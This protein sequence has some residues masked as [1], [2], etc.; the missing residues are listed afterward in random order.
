MRTPLLGLV[1][2]AFVLSGCATE[3]ADETASGEDALVGGKADTRWAASGYLTSDGKKPA[4]GATLISPNVVVTAAHCVKDANVAFS[5]GTGHVGSSPLVRVAERHAHPDF[6]PEKQ[7]H[8]D[9]THTL[10][11][12]D[13]AYL[14]LERAI[15]DVA[16]ATLPTAETRMWN[17]L[18]AIGYHGSERRS[19]PAYVTLQLSLGND[20]ILEVHPEDSSA[21]CIADG[22][23]GSAVVER[24]PSKQVLVGIFVG[25]VTG[26]L[27]DC[28][29]GTQYLNGYESAYGYADF[30]RAGI[31]N[32]AR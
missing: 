3:Q 17:K 23:D 5:F 19:T 16:P 22:D 12:Y 2:A 25:S 7:G 29:R 11:N 1:F 14:V 32:A 31:A 20:P 21:L 30:L 28:V 8:I 13:V 18:Q 10:R 9:L 27:T 6:H 24:D 15:T 4:C 26:G